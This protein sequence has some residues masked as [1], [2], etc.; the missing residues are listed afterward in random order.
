MSFNERKSL[1]MNYGRNNPLGRKR[2]GSQAPV[3]AGKEICSMG[4]GC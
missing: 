1:V 2:M 3:T 4:L